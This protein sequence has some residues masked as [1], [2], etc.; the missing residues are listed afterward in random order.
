MPFTLTATASSSLTVAYSSSNTAIASINGT[1]VT[2]NGAGTVSITAY[3]TGNTNYSAATSV[4][5]ILTVN[6]ASQSITFGILPLKTFGD[7]AFT[8]TATASSSLTVAYS[9]SNTAIASINGTS[10]TINGAGTVSITAYQTGNTNYSAATSVSRI[11]TVNQAS[12][13]I[14]FGILPLKTFGDGAFTLTAT[15]SSSLTVAYS[16][17]STAIASINGTSVTI[18][19]AG[20]VS[21]TAYQTGNTNYSA[22]TSV[23]RILTVNQASQSITFGI[24]PLK[25]FGD[26]PFKLTASVGGSLTVTFSSFNNSVASVITGDSLQIHSAGTVQIMALHTGDNNYLKDSVIRIFT[27]ANSN[28]RINFALSL[29]TFGDR[30]FKLTA[31]VGGSLTVT[32]SSFNNNVAS[33]I[34]GDSL[35][36]HSAGTVQIMARHTGDNNYLKDSVV[37]IF[38]VQKA[39]QSINFALSLKTFGD[40]PFKLTASVGGSLTVTFSSFNNSVASVITGD[41]LQIHSAGTVQI[42]ALHTGD[43]NYLKDSVIRIF[44]V[45]NSNQRINFALSLKTFGD[46]PFKLTAS[47]GGS[48]TVTFSS[49]NNSVASVITGDSLQIHSAGTV[50]IMARHTGDNNY[51][52]DSVVQ[53]FTVRKASHIISFE[54][55]PLKTY[56]DG[57]FKISAYSSSSLPLSFT[58][59]NTALVNIVGNDSLQIHGSGTVIITASQTGNGNYNP[60]MDVTQSFTI[61][62]KDIVNPQKIGQIMSFSLIPHLTVGQT[63][64]LTATT[65]SSLPVYFVSE[66]AKVTITGNILRADSTGAVNITAIQGGNIA[67]NPTTSTQNIIIYSRTTVNKMNQIINF[68]SI[69]NLTV[70]NTYVLQANASSSLLVTFL[71]SNTQIL[72]INKNTITVLNSGIASITAIQEGNELYNPVTV[73]QIFILHSIGKRNQSISFSSIPDMTVGKN[74]H[75][76]E[77]RASSSLPITFITSNGNV[78]INNTI[79]KALHS[80]ITIISATQPGNQDYNPAI[81]SHILLIYDITKQSQSISFINIPNELTVGEKFVLNATASSSLPVTFISLND[82]CSLYGN[83][84]TALKSGLTTI[85]ATQAGNGFYNPVTTSRNLEN[86]VIYAPWKSSQSITFEP[87]PRNLTIGQKYILTANATSLLPIKFNASNNN[88]RIDGNTLTILNSGITRITASQEGDIVYNP[89]LVWQDITIYTSSKINQIISLKKIPNLKV[90]ETHTLSA[91]TSSLLPITFTSS[92]TNILINGNIITALSPGVV[93]INANQAGDNIYNPATISQNVIIYAEGKKTQKITIGSIQ[94]ITVNQKFVL[95]ATSTSGLSIIFRSSNTNIIL[96]KNTVTALS[97]G[98]I[99]ITA[100]QE[101]NEEYNPT[102]AQTIFT[103]TDPTK[104]Y[105]VVTFEPSDFYTRDHP[106]VLNAVS[107]SNSNLLVKYFTSDD[108][109][110]SVENS[111]L[112]PI[113]TGKI[114][115]SAYQEGNEEYNPSAI[116]SKPTQI[117]ATKLFQFITFSKPNNKNVNDAPFILSAT[118]TSLLKVLYSTSSTI[119]NIKENT[120]TIK[121]GGLVGITAYQ[122]GNNI[123]N[124]AVSVVQFLTIHKLTQSINFSVIPTKTMGDLPFKLFATASSLLTVSYSSSNSTIASIVGNTVVIKNV[125]TIQITAYQLG[126]NIYQRATCNACSRILTI[127][128]VPT[129]HPLTPIEKGNPAIRIYP[130]PANDYITIQTDK[131]QTISS[132]QIYDITGASYELSV[133]SYELGLKVDVRKLPKGEYIIKVYG[134]DSMDTPAHIKLLTDKIIIK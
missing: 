46:R 117:I 124:E 81:G 88:V 80:G 101:G 23:S 131:T 26:R 104:R 71:N 8:L 1:S 38:T 29:K 84:I 7:G 57:R 31:S 62:Y 113:D 115:I 12:Q 36:I 95:T 130:N 110:A 125:G 123:Y 70:G 24:L 102:I 89:A 74:T 33:V 5:R 109:I 94:D 49:F 2:I 126:D 39:K 43:N 78:T 64:T 30:P 22:A 120:V 6:Q 63:I 25:T 54:A 86:V 116:V 32:F 56:G 18:N 111:T 72:S 97:S 119:I 118:S 128:A 66:N 37:Q 79:V 122:P 107:N 44:T 17:G 58:S 15:A 133:M 59:S 45:A 34:T 121:A 41:S 47:V 60:S 105:Q 127:S 92:H 20:T 73:S 98:V 106:H 55:L 87:I 67:Y 93:I 103:I 28:Q 4:S 91:S 75:Q 13:S 69:P 96:N 134:K 35:Q 53:I 51:L 129:T 48:L 42:M 85:V 10:V 50:Q 99:L 27:V 40:R 114:I 16:S 14:N 19:G 65:N 112:I 9:S 83:T 68:E 11:L 108:S 90:T 76:L 61:G 82:N 77:A 3:Q 52:K 132:V 21:I 100:I